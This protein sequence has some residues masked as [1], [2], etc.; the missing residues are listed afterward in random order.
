MYDSDAGDHHDGSGLVSSSPDSASLAEDIFS[1]IQYD[2][3]TIGNH[4]LYHYADAL[5]IY[6]HQE[7][8]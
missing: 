2:V 6:E 1:M 5:D 3:I 4:E 7:R 8:W